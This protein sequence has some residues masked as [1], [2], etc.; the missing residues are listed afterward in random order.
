MEELR[1]KE[2]KKERAEDAHH[3]GLTKA[4]GYLYAPRKPRK[5]TYT[6]PMNKRSGFKP[7]RQ[8]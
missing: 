5:S 3:A 4:L 1:Y 6:P 8:K 7:R 2:T